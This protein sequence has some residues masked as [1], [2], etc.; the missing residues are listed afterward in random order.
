MCSSD[1]WHLDAWNHYQA[2]GAAALYE[3][4]GILLNSGKYDWLSTSDAREKIVADL[5]KKGIAKEKVNYRMRDWSVSRQRYWGAP[6]PIIHCDD[7]GP[8]LVPDKELPVVLPELVD[9]AP[10]GDG[11][12]A[13]AR[14]TDWLHASCPKCGKDGERETDTLDTYICS[15]WYMLRYFNAHNAHDAFD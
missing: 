10:S 15:S 14:A 5:A 4:E 8:Q 12:S 6:I 3:G 7:C 1:L 9:F 11:R 2:G 13:L